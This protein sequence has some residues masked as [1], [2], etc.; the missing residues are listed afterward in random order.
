MVI[1]HAVSVI[2][3]WS[4]ALV[5]KGPT[6]FTLHQK[7]SYFYRVIYWTRY[8]GPRLKVLFS[9]ISITNLTFY[10]GVIRCIS[11]I[12]KCLFHFCVD[13]GCMFVTDFVSPDQYIPV[14]FVKSNLGCSPWS[15]GNQLFLYYHVNLWHKING[16]FWR[17]M[18]FCLK[19]FL[20]FS[21]ISLY[22]STVMP[23]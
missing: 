10:N 18:E 14:D 8:I 19:E 5:A 12:F 22:D 20:S 11:L 16:F 21:L 1:V 4:L 3:W 7:I 6:I 15:H 13:G 9:I 23:S 2:G 17:W